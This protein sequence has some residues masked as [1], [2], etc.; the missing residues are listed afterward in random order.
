MQSTTIGI[1]LAKSVFQLSVG[2]NATKIDQRLRLTRSQFERFLAQQ[3]HAQLVMEACATSHH[4]ARLASS[5]GHHVTLLHPAYVRPYVKRN[6]TDAADADALLKASQDRDLKPVPVKT[7]DQQALQALH[8]IRQQWIGTRTQRINLARSIVAEFGIPLPR[9]TRE[10]TARLEAHLETLPQGLAASLAIVINEI[11]DLKE[12]ISQLDKQLG[13]IARRDP[14]TQRLMTVPGIGVITATAMIASVPDIHRFAKG[15]QFSSW[16]GLTP[17][18]SSSGHR[19]HLG[20]ISKQ[21]NI[22]LRT[23]LI[24]G[25]RSALLAAQRKASAGKSLDSLE[26]W[27][28]TLKQHRHHNIVAFALANKL[29]RITWAV[30]H[31]EADYHV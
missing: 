29:A 6:K 16:L 8:R 22:Y 26:Q 9:G 4:W 17:R 13:E 19:Q 12:K 31:K 20:S 11:R 2:R 23:L 15:R 24:H 21:G 1:D 14:I 18:E 28:V 3:P 27:A 5:Q 10:I 25:A 30:W 7:V